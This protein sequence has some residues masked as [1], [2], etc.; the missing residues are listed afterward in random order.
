MDNVDGITLNDRGRLG[1]GIVVRD[2]K[3]HVVF[4]GTLECRGE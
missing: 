2:N 3:G 1:I 4:N